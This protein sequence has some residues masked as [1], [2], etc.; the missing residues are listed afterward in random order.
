MTRKQAV[1]RLLQLTSLT[2]QTP[3]F[4]PSF[5]SAAV[6]PDGLS[7]L[8]RVHHPPAE[9]P[10]PPSTIP[11]SRSPAHSDCLLR[12]SHRPSS[13]R[14]LNELPAFR[15]AYALLPYE[16]VLDHIDGR[17]TR[18][19]V[20]RF[21]RNSQYIFE[22]RPT[23]TR[24][25]AKNP[26]FNFRCRVLNENLCSKLR[27]VLIHGGTD[28]CRLSGENFPGKPPRVKTTDWFL[29]DHVRVL[30]LDRGL[31]FQRIHCTIVAICVFSRMNSP[32]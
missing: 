13:H 15:P 8:Q 5:S 9:P 16:P 32:C 1:G 4:S 25:W 19:C 3:S 7:R 28:E 2:T 14:D 23:I 30:F 27:L 31:N 11:S 24:P 22:F 6:P 20:Y 18:K 26:G 10:S 12:S 17:N 29:M 21:L